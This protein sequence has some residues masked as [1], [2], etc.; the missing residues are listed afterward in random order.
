MTDSGKVKKSTMIQ[1]S[2]LKPTKISTF[3]FPHILFNIK[4]FL[5]KPFLSGRPTDPRRAL[6]ARLRRA[7]LPQRG[8]AGEGRHHRRDPQPVP[9]PHD[10][11]GLL[12]VRLLQRGGREEGRPR[13]ERRGRKEDDLRVRKQVRGWKRRRRGWSGEVCGEV[14][15]FGK[16]VSCGEKFQDENS[17]FRFSI[18]SC[19]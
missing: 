18:R 6:L 17:S 8:A 13:G 12:R 5:K 10:V 3:K 19:L 1:K 7:P 11:Q 9:P 16:C 15:A 14:K 4:L 2:F